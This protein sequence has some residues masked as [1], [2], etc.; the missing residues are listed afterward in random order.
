MN[1]TSCNAF[2]RTAGLRIDRALVRRC[3]TWTL[4]VDGAQHLSLIHI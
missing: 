1:V 4:S 3:D 2:L